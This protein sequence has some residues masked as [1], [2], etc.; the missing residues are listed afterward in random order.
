[1]TDFSVLCLR[2]CQL[3]GALSLL[4][5]SLPTE[6]AAQGNIRVFK[7]NGIDYFE[8]RS[9]VNAAEALAT[10]RGY[11]PNDQDVWYPLAV[12]YYELNELPEARKLFE[13]LLRAGGKVPENTYLYLG[14]IDHHEGKFAEAAERYKA[15]LGE[16]ENESD[17]APSVI[18]DLRRVG[19]ASKLLP[20]SG[21]MAAYAENLGAGV[22][23]P[24]DD[25]HPLLSPNYSDRM[26]FATVREGV[27]GGLRD[28]RDRGN[29]GLGSDM[30]S[31]QITNGRWST[32]EPLSYVLNT[33]VNEVA[34]DFAGGG[35]VLMFWRGNSLYS[36]D[37]HVDTFRAQRQARQLFSPVWNASPVRTDRGDTD[38]TFFNDSTIVY[39]SPREDGEGGYDIYVT[40]RIG[41]DWRLPQNLGPQIN[42]AYDERSPYLAADGRTLY[43]SSNRADRSIGGYDVFRV[44]FDDRTGTWGEPEN[45]G[46]AINSAGD[47]LNFRLA[48][49]GI[50]GYYD[51]TVRT[52]SLGGRDIYVA[53]FKERLIEQDEPSSPLT[54][55][56]VLDLRRSAVA[57]GGLPGSDSAGAVGIERIPVSLETTP[58]LYGSDDNVLTSANLERV[59]PVIQFLEKYPE[60]RVVITAHTDDSDPER[61]RAYFG[62][63][64]AERFAAYLAQRGIAAERI[65]LVSVGSLYPI[66]NNS[67]GGNPSEQGQRLNRRIELHVVPGERYRLTER[68]AD[69]KVPDFLK[70]NAYQRYRAQQDGVWFRIELATLPQMFDNDAWMRVPVPSIQ[71]SGVSGP[72]RYAAGAF[73][74]YRSA[75]QMADEL[76]ENGFPNAEVVAYLDGVRLT[77]DEVLR[78]APLYPELTAYRERELS[79]EPPASE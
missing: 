62:I 46:T 54:F 23:G 35:K 56:D 33:A 11:K 30:Y 63:K 16:V 48:K 71:A 69:A 55:V 78:F 72:Y 77:S 60:S 75:T 43:F 58:L 68:F 19:Y 12:S 38:P 53:Y 22:N 29:P 36:G 76:L 10:Y 70:A 28:A 73:G 18:D 5:C 24:G 47:E 67:Q 41:G 44:Q 66:A 79:D 34:L 51:S 64:R 39:S 45:A 3:A 26:Y 14:R 49:N 1:M 61:F 59:R 42:T 4:W 40:T 52:T 15:Y 37:I 21:K 31:A 74:T 25:F 8:Q 50:E 20:N 9:Y 17:L 32:P 6:A 13:G 2:A 65:S 27:T 7:R 57:N